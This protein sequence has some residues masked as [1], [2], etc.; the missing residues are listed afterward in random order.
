M[1]IIIRKM[2]TES[3]MTYHLPHVRKVIMKQMKDG[4]DEGGCANPCTL[5]VTM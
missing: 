3:I 1:S 4:E 5:S 2:Q